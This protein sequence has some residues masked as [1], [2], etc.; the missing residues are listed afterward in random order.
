MSTSSPPQATAID[1]T[2]IDDVDEFFMQ[3]GYT[4]GLPVILPQRRRVEAML[5]GTSLP[6][7]EV[8]G[9]VPPSYNP[10]TVEFASIAAV[11]A[12]CTPEMFRL[13]L[14]S[15][16]GILRSEY[17]LHG[18]HATTMGATPVVV[19]N[20]ACRHTASVNFTHGV[21][22]SGSRSTSI[23][24]ALKL[25]I[26]N[27][28]RA[29]LRGTESTTI[30]TPMKFGLCLGE[31]EERASMWMPLAVE[32]GAVHREEDAVTVTAASSGPVQIVDVNASPAELP[33][34]LGKALAAA[35]SPVLPL[36]SECMLVISPEHYDTLVAGGYDS[37]RKVQE[38]LWK[39]ASVHMGPAIPP[40]LVL[41]G[42]L[43]FPK[44][45][46]IVFR[47][48]GHLLRLLSGSVQALGVKW[49]PLPKFPQPEAL[50]IVMAGGEAGKFSSFMPGFGVGPPGSAG[51]NMS[52]PVTERVEPR[53]ETLDLPKPK[54]SPDDCAVL[55]PV[56]KLDAGMA[57][58]LASRTGQLPDVIG[59][60]DISKVRGSELLD[61]IEK[62]LQAR[63]ARTRRYCKPTF[64][65][66]CPSD[67]RRRVASE[68]RGVVLGLAD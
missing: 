21:C 30:G 50:Q 6:R 56:V 33:K 22:G 11:M 61:V 3:Q 27:V 23:C 51:A 29:K 10:V 48:L 60:L 62:K 67:L 16:R 9:M 64:S 15:L 41:L 26:Q 25:I 66:P 28:G 7:E 39:E 13:V 37:K 58:G 52:R 12:G 20:G 42:K 2:G 24:R 34:R 18:V 5:R 43:R 44:V 36:V 54:V 32:R 8:L 53:P 19:V 17:G 38:V 57:G 45:P 47:V 55:C 65:R 68:C 4:D 31:W 49:T 63:G 14:A 46:S 59:L 1:V 35:Y 40:S